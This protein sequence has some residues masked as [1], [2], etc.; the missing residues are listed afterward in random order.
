AI[1]V[2]HPVEKS[3]C[4]FATQRNEKRGFDV[5]LIIGE[6][7]INAHKA[8]LCARIPFMRALFDMKGSES[9]SGTINLSST[10]YDST[11]IASLIDFAYTGTITISEATVT[12][13]MISANYFEMV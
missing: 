7:T 12:L 13:L 9:T 10:L 4:D 11:T 5:T 8:V 1:S 6:T 2:T 3:L